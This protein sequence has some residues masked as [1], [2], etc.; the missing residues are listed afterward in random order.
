M[1]QITDRDVAFQVEQ[2]LPPKGT[3]EREG[4]DTDAIVAAII[5]GYGLVDIDT[6]NGDEF[7]ALVR[8]HDTTQQQS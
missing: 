2:A 5:D 7:W 3:P 8:E 4:I 6:I 1:Q